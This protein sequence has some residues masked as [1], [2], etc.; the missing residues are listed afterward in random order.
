MVT[1]VGK[2]QILEK[3]GAGGFGSVFKGRDPFIK[4]IVAIKT[5]QSDEDEIKKRFFRE[6]EFAGNLHHRNVTT[7]YDFGVTDEGVPYIVQEFLTGED[8]DR[9][10]KNKEPLPLLRKVRILVDIADGL[11]YAHANGIV[12]RDIKPSNVRILE[13]GTVKIMDFGIAKSM[14]SHSTL[15]QTGITLGTASYLAPE[16][17]RG[18]DVDPRTDIFSLGVLAY[19]LLTYQ[20]PFMGEHIST[21]LYKILNEQPPLPHQLDPAIPEELSRTVMRMIEKDRDNRQA[22]CSEVRQELADVEGA[23][24]TE[25]PAGGRLDSMSNQPDMEKTVTTPTGGFSS[26]VRSGGAASTG[27][28]N[29]SAEARQIP[30]SPTQLGASPLTGTLAD[31]RIGREE[32]APAGILATPPPSGS[33]ALRIFLGALALVVVAGGAGVYLYLHRPAPVASGLSSGNPAP[34]PVAGETPTTTEPTVPSSGSVISSTQSPKIEPTAVPTPAPNATAAPISVGTAEFKANYYSKLIVDGRSQKPVEA[35]KGVRLAG[36]KP[37]SHEAIFR[38]DGYP[39]LKMR[40]EVRPGETTAVT[41]EFA[42]KG[43]LKIQ[44]SPEARDAV[45]F[46]DG[47]K[48]GPAPITQIVKAGPHKVEAV[49][50]GFQPW[51]DT[52][53]VPEQDVKSVRASL[54]RKTAAP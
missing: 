53:E 28:R 43:Q 4:R 19:E 29:V 47:K 21:V 9:K 16:Q 27:S 7:I 45:Y 8:L 5:C 25:S 36:L 35:A 39:D 34:S 32:T 22:T 1:Q 50:E 17:I 51:S 37:G 13:D 15:T 3:I 48:V 33:G 26:M 6:A 31:M 44:V 41:A 46:V 52:V 10:I 2:Y 18:E 30:I 23:I 24:T 14:V 11:G 42:A 40:F 54:V 20:K 12:H 38:T 49:V